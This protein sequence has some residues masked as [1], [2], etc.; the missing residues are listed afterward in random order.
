MDLDSLRQSIAYI[1]ASSKIA[2]DTLRNLLD[3]LT[4]HLDN[5]VQ[6][7][8]KA[9]GVS[10]RL[11]ELEIKLTTKVRWG[12]NNRAYLLTKK[13]FRFHIKIQG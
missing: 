12:F 1:P 11:E 3:P 10:R 9:V 5:G 8:I 4:W 13:F 7:A 2:K 6:N